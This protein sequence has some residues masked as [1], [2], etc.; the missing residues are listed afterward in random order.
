MPLSALNQTPEGYLSGF[1][2]GTIVSFD[3][4][5]NLIDSIQ[6]GDEAFTEVTGCIIDNGDSPD[7]YL[8]Q[9]GGCILTQIAE[10]SAAAAAAAAADGDD[11]PLISARKDAA[12]AIF[13]RQV[14]C[15]SLICPSSA[16]CQT[17]AISAGPCSGCWRI[18]LP[19]PSLPQ[20]PF[21]SP[22]GYCLR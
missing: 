14:A 5:D 6:L 13:T 20:I 17:Q 9:P 4:D 22:I 18:L 1:V 12:S 11:I 8:P 19:P 16:Y 15:T 2:N 3:A 10:R 21:P 7:G